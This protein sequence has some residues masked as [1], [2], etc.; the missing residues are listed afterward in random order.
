MIDSHWISTSLKSTLRK[1]LKR[2]IKRKRFFPTVQK[3][4]VYVSVNKNGL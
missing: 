2:K 3:A 4:D 1:K